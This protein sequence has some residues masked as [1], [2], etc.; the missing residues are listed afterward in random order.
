MFRRLDLKRALCAALMLAALP[1]AAAADETD[2]P[3]PLALSLG[4]LRTTLEAAAVR[5]AIDYAEDLGEVNVGRADS[6]G[7]TIL[8]V[9]PDVRI[10][11]GDQ[12]A[13][14]SIVAKVS[15][16]VLF[17]PGMTLVDGIWVEDTGA[18]FH[19]LPISLGV[20]SGRAFDTVNALAEIGYVPWYYNMTN[21]PAFVRRTKVGLFLQSGYKFASD[22]DVTAAGDAGGDADESEEEPEHALL[23]L[24]GSVKLDPRVMFSDTKGASLI[25]RADAWWDIANSELYYRVDVTLRFLLTRE[26]FLDF[27][28][29]KGAGAPTF[30][31]GEQF[32]ANLTLMF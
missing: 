32:S 25:G 26:R 31:E 18:F 15:G 4:M 7:S 27:V 23:R 5:Y 8:A 17:F 29:E 30:N 14:K 12:D 21:L 11:T 3:R 6:T 24:K 13:F 20:E 10:E 2:G 1:G 28:Y 22:E 9:T 16:N 19:A